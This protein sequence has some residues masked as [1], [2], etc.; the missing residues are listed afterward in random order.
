MATKKLLKKEAEALRQRLHYI[1]SVIDAGMWTEE[2]G[3]ER[4]Q[5][6]NKLYFNK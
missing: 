1:D 6:I 5:I 4:A 3:K 2:L